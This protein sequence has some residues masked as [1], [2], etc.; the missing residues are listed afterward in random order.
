MNDL[1]I[2][3]RNTNVFIQNNAEEHSSLKKNPNW[4]NPE[5]VERELMICTYASGYGLKS[6]R[7]C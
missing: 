6:S 3:Y 2:C 7:F 5:K 4:K 1:L